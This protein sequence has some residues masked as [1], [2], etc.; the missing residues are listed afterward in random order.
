VVY[1][2]LDE[3]NEDEVYYDNQEEEHGEPILPEEE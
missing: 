1:V 3:D 2:V